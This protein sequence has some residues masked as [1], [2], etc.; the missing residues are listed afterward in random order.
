MNTEM[1]PNMKQEAIILLAG[2]SLIAGCATHPPDVT[3]NYQ[4]ITGKRTDLMSENILESPQQPPREVVWL[5]AARVFKDSWNSQSVDYLEVNYM[6]RS[7]TGFLEIPLGNTLTLV[8]DGQEMKL[9]GIGSFNKRKTMKN[10]FVSEVALYEVTREQLAKIAFAKQV[11]V[12]IK[13]VNGVV[14]RDFGAENFRRFQE[15]LEAT[16]L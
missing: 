2:L 5:N 1:K 10:N 13:G 15:F 8:A 4:P 14:E 9:S 7:E 11:K 3:T 6:A 16:R 12:R